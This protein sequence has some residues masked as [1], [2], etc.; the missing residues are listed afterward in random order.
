MTTKKSETCGQTN[1]LT[2]FR[3]SYPNRCIEEDGTSLLTI[4]LG[5]VFKRAKEQKGDTK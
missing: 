4:M 2:E 3:K 5:D 1:P